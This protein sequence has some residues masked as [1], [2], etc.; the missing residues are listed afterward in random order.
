MKILITN[1]DG[2]DSQPMALLA[3]WA[4]KHGEVT[5]VVPK[6]E[7]SGK[8]QA[9]EFRSP[10][11][12]KRV[13]FIE[14]CEAYTVDSTPADCVRF[15]INGL[16]RK[17]DIVFS[18]INRGYNL[19]EDISYSGTVGTILEAGRMGVNAIALSADIGDFEHAL[20][21]LDSVYEFII[22][23]DL[24]S[25]AKLLNVN[26]PT[27]KSRGIV[28]T[29][30]GSMFYSDDFVSYGNDMYLQV[31]EPLK[32]CDEDISSDIIA[33]QK[34][35]ISITPLTFKKTDLVAYDRLKSLIK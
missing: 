8:S 34:G 6:V 14:G 30:Q 10:F 3:K 26:F 9:I 4:M 5:V 1:D 32:Y 25:H 20:S 23:N 28:I 13:D 19:G 33:V 18:G 21:E 15:A 31:G 27:T 11:E 24:L 29:Y 35:Y 16:G 12:I 2:I 17:Y 22:K 7:Q